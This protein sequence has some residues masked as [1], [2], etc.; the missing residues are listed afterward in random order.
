MTEL[1]CCILS[2]LIYLLQICMVVFF[3][4]PEILKIFIQ[5]LKRVQSVLSAEALLLRHGFPMDENE[6]AGNHEKKG[7]LIG[8]FAPS[9]S[10]A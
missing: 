8:R 7:S 4:F 1:G 5:L 9:R 6:A 3:I 10:P 2:A